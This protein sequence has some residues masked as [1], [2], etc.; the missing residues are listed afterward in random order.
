MKCK[1]T[2][3]LWRTYQNLCE[4][5]VNRITIYQWR[6]TKY[7]MLTS[8]YF[9]FHHTKHGFKYSKAQVLRCLCIRTYN[10]QNK[11]NTSILQGFNTLSKSTRHNS[12][13]TVILLCQYKLIGQLTLRLLYVWSAGSHIICYTSIG[14]LSGIHASVQVVIYSSF[15]FQIKA[16]NPHGQRMQIMS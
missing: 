10:R 14:I 15:T 16:K 11:E 6:L 12:F 2:D 13:F 7:C 4:K 1:T 5:Y 9:K 3:F 8:K